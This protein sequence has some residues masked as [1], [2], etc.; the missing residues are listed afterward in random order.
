MENTVTSNP[1][2]ALCLVRPRLLARPVYQEASFI[3][4]PVSEIFIS[5]DLFNNEYFVF[6]SQSATELLHLDSGQRSK[7]EGLASIAKIDKYIARLGMKGVVE[8]FSGPLLTMS[9]NVPS[10]AIRASPFSTTVPMC[11][12]PDVKQQATM[13]ESTPVISGRHL[14]KRQSG[15][16]VPTTTFSPLTPGLDLRRQETMTPRKEELTEKLASLSKRSF[17]LIHGDGSTQEIT[18]KIRK[19]TLLIIKRT[20]ELVLRH[21]DEKKALKIYSD[22]L[23]FRSSFSDSRDFTHFLD[24]IQDFLA[25]ESGIGSKR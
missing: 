10:L 3:G 19:D 21:F 25:E 14:P 7:I 13:A 12:T 16:V 15:L 18:V 11:E 5:R 6:P 22:W 24:F 1:D 2:A 23:I 17:K 8:L 4:A 9:V 20:F